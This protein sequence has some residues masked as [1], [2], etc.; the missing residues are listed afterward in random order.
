AQTGGNKLASARLLGIS[1]ATLYDRMT[2]DQPV[3][4]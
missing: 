1:R 4:P 3:R 2:D